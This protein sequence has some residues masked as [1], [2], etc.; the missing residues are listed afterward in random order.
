[1]TEELLKR[2]KYL[3]L[4]NSGDYSEGET[5]LPLF[6][7]RV[8]QLISVEHNRFQTLVKEARRPTKPAVPNEPDSETG[9][10]A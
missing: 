8:E 6:V 4:T 10:G 3:Y 5:A 1:M 7:D 2:E 9:Q